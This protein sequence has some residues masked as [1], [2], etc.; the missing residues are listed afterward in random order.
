LL[1]PL[2]QISH[3]DNLP[4]PQGSEQSDISSE[5]EHAPPESRVSGGVQTL[6]QLPLYISSPALHVLQ[7]GG[8]LAPLLQ[9]S[10]D[11]NLPSPQGSEQSEISSEQEQSPLESCVYGY[12]Q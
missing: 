11:D 9:I 1:A 2:L 6:T 7:S 4:S 5:Q 12:A 8:L 3:D 10:H